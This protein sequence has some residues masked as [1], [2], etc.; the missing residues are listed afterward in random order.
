MKRKPVASKEL[1]RLQQAIRLAT[2]QA[3]S[4]EVSQ[5]LNELFSK[6]HHQKSEGLQMKITYQQL[7]HIKMSD[8]EKIDTQQLLKFAGAVNRLMID[9]ESKMKRN[10]IGIVMGMILREM[11]HRESAK[12]QAEEA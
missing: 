10:S 6:A 11:E 7:Q 4:K 9:E 12:Q 3:G 8:L 5:I 1:H 2:Q